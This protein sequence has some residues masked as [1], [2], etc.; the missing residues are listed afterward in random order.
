MAFGDYL[1]THLYLLK[2]ASENKY[3]N[4]ALWVILRD[5]AIKDILGIYPNKVDSDIA[6][7]IY[8]EILKKNEQYIPEYYKVILPSN[9]QERYR[10]AN[11]NVWVT[12]AF[13]PD[14]LANQKEII[15]YKKENFTKKGKKIV[16]QGGV[17][18]VNR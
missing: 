14:G 1:K 12:N 5:I 4:K 15:C 13:H 3:S 9:K 11:R 10:I 2:E 7:P 17:N 8:Y 18:Y 6:I 16:Y